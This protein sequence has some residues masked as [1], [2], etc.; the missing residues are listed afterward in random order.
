VSSDGPN[1]ETVFKAT[2]DYPEKIEIEDHPDA[3][4]VK[5]R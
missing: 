2:Y 3:P 4:L 1:A 5:M